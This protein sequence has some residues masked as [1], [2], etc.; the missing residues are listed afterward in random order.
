MKSDKDENVS[1]NEDVIIQM[2]NVYKAFGQVEAVNNVSL[3]VSR[4]EVVVIIGPSGSGKSTL[5]RCINHLESI[6][7]GS[8]IVDGIPLDSK[9]NVNKVRAEVGIVFQQFN[10]FP[11]LTAMENITLPQR[12]VRK[13]SLKEAERIASDLLEQVGIPEK[14]DNYPSAF[15]FRNARNPAGQ[16][17]DRIPY[18]FV[19]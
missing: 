10:L 8:I 17:P 11:H 3:D 15:P 1:L 16:E 5:L 6:N 12:V 2:R 7:K 14:A 13:R 19:Q 4:G 18:S 9:A